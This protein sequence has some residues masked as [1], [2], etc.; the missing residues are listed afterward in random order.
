MSKK[1]IFFDVDGTLLGPRDGELFCVPPSTLRALALL[2][3]RGHRIAVCSGRQEAFILRHF[4][5]I[6]DSYVALNGAHVVCDGQTVVF[7]EYTPDRVGALLKHFDSFG[8]RYSFV[9][10]YHAWARNL[11]DMPLPRLEASYGVPDYV[12]TDWKQ[13]NVHA[14]MMDFFFL[15]EAE[16]RRCLPAFADEAMVL[17]YHLGNIAGD[18]SFKGEDKASGIRAFLNFTGTARSDT[19]AFGDGYNDVSM[20][21]AV[22]L[23]VA[24]GNAVDEVKQAAGYVTDP[25]FE[26]GIFNALTHLGLI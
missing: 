12:V 4:P 2:R 8:C 22:G 19:V 14:S 23:G 13:E 16:Y 11:S 9:G 5:G 26:D 21:H 7:R 1:T 6:F 25:I 3:E 18:L 17:N 10:R 24:M 20:M 15:D